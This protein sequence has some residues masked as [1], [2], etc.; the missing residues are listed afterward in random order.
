ML[1]V[2]R[3]ENTRST[4]TESKSLINIQNMKFEPQGSPM[5]SVSYYLEFQKQLSISKGSSGKRLVDVPAEQEL[6]SS[7]A[8]LLS[9]NRTDF[10]SKYP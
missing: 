6:N 9:R 5:H 4:N 1:S 7:G 10:I 8:W 3:R 2:W